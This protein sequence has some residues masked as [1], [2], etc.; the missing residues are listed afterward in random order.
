M[1]PWRRGRQPATED[2]LYRLFLERGTRQR[3]VHKWHHYFEVY[4]RFLSRFR[5]QGTVVLEIGVFEG[6]SMEMWRAWFGPGATIAGID[7][8]PGCEA[9]APEGTRVFIGN[10]AEPEF[11]ARVVAE[12]GVPD[13][14]IDDGGHTANQQITSFETIYPLMGPEGIYIVEDTH[15]ALWGGPFDDRPDGRSF[16]DYAFDRCRDLHAWTGRQ[17]NFGR[18]GTPPAER[19]GP[20]PEV[21]EFT[22]RT[23]AISFFDSM[24]V[25][26]RQDRPEPWH[27]MR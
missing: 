21:P 19:T 14:V 10:Q 22:R 8:D 7:I 13:V 18:F 11:L 16:L 2:D 6:G 12:I 25:F 26:E 15:T 3:T 5:G 27:E 17:E 20:A 23:R 9:R 24:V 1:W 4:S